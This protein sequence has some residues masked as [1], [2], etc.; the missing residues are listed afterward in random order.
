MHRRDLSTCAPTTEADTLRLLAPACHRP[1]KQR[2]VTQNPT[3][4]AIVKLLASLN[5]HR[6]GSPAAATAPPP[7]R[8]KDARCR[9]PSLIHSHHQRQDVAGGALATT[10]TGA[11][12][13]FTINTSAREHGATLTNR[14]NKYTNIHIYFSSQHIFFYIYTKQHIF[15]LHL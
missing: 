13:Y 5:C 15:F 4:H 6:H 3:L 9:K 11:T 2:A 12:H 14:R 8:H 7:R 1:R 10:S